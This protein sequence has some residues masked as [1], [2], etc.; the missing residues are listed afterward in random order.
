M[1]RL[2]RV[3]LAVIIL[4]VTLSMLMFVLENQQLVAL[5]FLGWTAP[6]FPISIFILSAL[7]VGMLVG[8]LI[9]IWSRRRE[10]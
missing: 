8:P 5:S 4:V 1:Y 9:R 3:L 6:R 7:L 2:S 10:R